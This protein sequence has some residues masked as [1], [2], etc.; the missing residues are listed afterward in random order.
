MNGL[1]R[2]CGEEIEQANKLD[3]CKDIDRVYYIINGGRVRPILWEIFSLMY[4]RR[5]PVTIYEFEDHVWGRPIS[6]HAMR[7]HIYE[8]RARLKG[9]QMKI[10][11][12]GDRGPH[13]AW[14]LVGVS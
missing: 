10:I 3:E 13:S 7:Q 4:L 2:R 14:E 1:C 12:H 11:T 5:R 9:S 6:R 8:L